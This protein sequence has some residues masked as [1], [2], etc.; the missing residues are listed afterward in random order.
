MAFIRCRICGEW[1]FE[2]ACADHYARHK[3]AKPELRFDGQRNEE[4]SLPPEER[5]QGSLD[6]VPRAYLHSRCGVA[7]G[8]PEYMIRSYLADP[9]RHADGTFCCGCNDYVS[10]GELSWITTGQNLAEYFAQLRKAHA[11]G[12]G[13]APRDGG[14]N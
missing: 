10:A 3:A 12:K 1:L 7:T 2:P 11:D 14:G 13:A 5:Y 4:P 8:M 9:F 6:G